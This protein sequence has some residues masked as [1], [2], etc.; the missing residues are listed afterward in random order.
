M[1]PSSRTGLC[2]A[3]AVGE[4]QRQQHLFSH[5]VC[6]LTRLSAGQLVVL[7]HF[8]PP[9]PPTASPSL[10]RESGLSDIT[11]PLFSENQ[12]KQNQNQNQ[13]FSSGPCPSPPVHPHILFG[14]GVGGTCDACIRGRS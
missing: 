10:C 2:G 12:K 7:F 11:K 3:A 9:T 14:V 6:P 5:T 4:G 13:P 1:A 8:T